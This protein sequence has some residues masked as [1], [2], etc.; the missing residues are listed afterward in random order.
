MPNEREDPPTVPGQA[1]AADEASATASLRVRL[2]GRTHSIRCEP[3]DTILDAV[4][5]AGLKAPFACQA[6]NCGTC[7][8]YLGE[9][10]ATMRANNV[11]AADE[12]AE[13]WVLTCQAT[14]TSREILVDYDR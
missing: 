10:T 5:R 6:G 7:M 8:A 9:G 3:G 11:L 2:E 4:R 14:P 13:G 1:S 12:V